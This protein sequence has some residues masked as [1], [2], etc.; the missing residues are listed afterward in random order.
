MDTEEDKKTEGV[1]MFHS[2]TATSYC[3]IIFVQREK[4]KIWLEDRSSKKQW[5]TTYMRKDEYV[6]SANVFA[7]ATSADY[8]SLFEQSLISPLDGAD[9][10]QRK[11]TS[12]QDD[13]LRLEFCATIRLLNSSR[14]IRYAF[15][16]SPVAV[17]RIQI[18]E[19][20]MRD[21]QEALDQVCARVDTT[22]AHLYAESEAWLS[23][24]KLVWKTKSDKKF[25]FAEKKNGI[26]I[27]LPGLYTLAVVVNHVPRA[28]GTGSI[29][30]YVDGVKIQAAAI[31]A[32][33]AQV[34]VVCTNTALATD[35][36]S[37][38]TAPP[39]QFKSI[40]L[41]APHE[42]PRN[43]YAV[44]QTPPTNFHDEGPLLNIEEGS[45][46]PTWILYTSVAISMLEAFH[47][48]WSNSQVNLSTFNNTETCNARP[49]EEGTCL[50]FPGH[51]KTTWTLLVNAWIVGGMF[52]SL[53]SGFPSNKWG[54]RTTLRF[55]AIIIMVLGSVIQVVANNPTWFSV[56]RFV[57]GVANGVAM[58]VVNTFLNAIS[59]PHNRHALGDAGH[60]RRGDDVLSPVWLVANGEDEEAEKE[61]AR[62]Y[63]KEN[64]NVLMGWIQSNDRRSKLPSMLSGVSDKVHA[65][66]NWT[67]LTNKKFR[68]PLVI[69]LGL[70][71]INQLVGINAVFFYSSSILKDAGISDSRAGLMII[72]I[73]N[74]IPVSIAAAL[75]KVM[76]KRTMLMSGI[77]VM[78]L[79]C[80]GMTFSLVYS[81]GWLSIVFL[82][83]FVVGYDLSIGPLL[84]PIVAE[85]F[86]DSARGAAVGICI[87]M[88][89]ICSLIVGIGFPYVEDAITNYSFTPFL[90]TT[91]LSIIFIYFMV[92]E[93]SDM[94]IAEI[95]D[96]FRSDRS[97]QS[98]SK[99]QV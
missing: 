52:G 56:G 31:G 64:V 44:V 33:E 43:G 7:D 49:V 78:V 97:V 26:K 85:L 84:W 80:I 1:A 25:G 59:T 67:I 21:H 53:L 39:N 55:N 27:H 17:D 82:G 40:D 13:T 93:T 73:L 61:L 32:E 46:R 95:Q 69:A 91:I 74:V 90:G 18:L 11:L 45:L 83:V 99:S 16:L 58:A 19:A 38:F 89:W 51:T 37:Y 12:L 57:S 42:S 48:G 30:I 23:K 62:L 88:K 68:K 29:S 9:D 50:M 86:A 4:L 98:S 72:D 28:G 60:L 87:T 8:A 34:A 2:S 77:F 75:T 79:C 76:R 14:C 15:D 6:T 41:M 35:L 63:G 70:T 36:V 92:P 20:K 96:G 81:V 24:S 3:Y 71:C 94:T 22:R 47:Y 5:Q 65:E 66:T 10:V 54:R